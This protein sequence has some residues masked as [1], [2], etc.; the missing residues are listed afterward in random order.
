MITES[1]YAE[2][3]HCDAVMVGGKK[4]TVCGYALEPSSLTQQAQE[5]PSMGYDVPDQ[6]AKIL[7]RP[8]HIKKILIS[9]L[10]DIFRKYQ[11]CL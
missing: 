4:H 7:F 10:V 8:I 5:G 9:E 6:A 3:H 1:Q 2:S 11:V